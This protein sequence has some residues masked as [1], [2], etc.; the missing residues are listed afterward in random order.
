MRISMARKR[1]AP[2][3][4]PLVGRHR[5]LLSDPKVREWYEGRLLRSRVSADTY[6][7]QVGLFAE[8]LELD[9]GAL[10]RVARDDPDRLRGLLTRLASKQ[11]AD[12]L[13]DAYISKSFGGLKSWLEFNHVRFDGYPKL[14]PIKG[15]SL[16]AERVP[17]PE[18]LGRVLERLSLRGRVIALLMAHSGV[19]PGVIGSYGGERGLRLGDLPELKLGPSPG[20]GAAPFVVRVPGTLSKTRAAYTTFGTQQLASAVLAY[21]E[22]RRE[23][24]EKLSAT[25]PVVTAAETRGIARRSRESARFGSGFLTTKAVT[26]EIREAL[27][28]T[29]PDGVTWRPYVLRSY[30]STRLLLAEGQGKIGRDLREAILGHDGGV[31]ARYNVGKVWGE[32]L[33][34]EAREAYHRCEPFLSTVK[35]ETAVTEA[36]L[37]KAILGVF[38]SEDEVAKMDVTKVTADDVRK[39]V[40]E[41][42]KGAQTAMTAPA[43]WS[44]PPHTPHPQQN[45]NEGAN[46]AGSTLEAVVPLNEVKVRLAEGW[47]WVALLGATDAILRRPE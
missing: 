19:R 26:E 37:K 20:F 14:A 28:A 43:A 35:T 12:G 15:Q 30:C 25:S 39:L 10:I 36:D 5:N 41:K 27:N 32:E 8:R 40:G 1:E 29:V 38:L 45:G 17:M 3:P 16:A 46:G 42:L 21:L 23:R 4:I 34:H 11:K 24:K 7:R 31:S 6:L 22:A 47:T 33:L 2:A 13:L 44:L 9:T 18:E